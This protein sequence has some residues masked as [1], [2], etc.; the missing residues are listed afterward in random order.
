MSNRPIGSLPSQMIS[1]YSRIQVPLDAPQSP[2]FA[3][4]QK[5]ACQTP[6]YGSGQADRM[7]YKDRLLGAIGGGRGLATNH[8]TPSAFVGVFSG[9]GT[10]DNIGICLAL[11]ARH[12]IFHHHPHR[13]SFTEAGMTMEQ[14][15]QKVANAYIGLDC[16]GFV[17]NWAIYNVV[18]GASASHLPLDWL[19]GR[20]I[21]SNYS[22]ISPYDIVVWANGFHI[23]MIERLGLI[24]SSKFSMGVVLAESSSGG[25]LL[26]PTTKLT[27]SSHDVA[28]ASG[29]W[30]T[31][32][33]LANDIHGNM[34]VVIASMAKN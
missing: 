7:A 33:S 1:A 22:E 3:C 10:M 14:R 12:R 13:D 2:V 28:A 19:Q 4:V 32:F 18:P 5:Y 8:L 15:L 31:H 27:R 6:G 21:R 20:R 16:N 23:A 26:H 11:A 30:R 34:P 24:D 17:G 25:M 9:K 29:P